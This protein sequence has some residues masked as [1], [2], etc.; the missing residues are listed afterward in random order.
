VWQE[1]ATSAT[2]SPYR[3]TS[4][5]MDRRFGSNWLSAGVSRLEEKQSLLGGRMGSALGGG[6]SASLFLDVEARRRLGGGWS[7]GLSARRGWTDFAAGKFQSGAYAFDLAKS[8]IFSGSDR[9]GLRVAQPLRIERGGFAAW[10]PTSYDYATEAAANSLSRLSLTPS[11]R[12]V[13]GELS[14]GTGLFDGRGWVGG[15]LFYRREP[16]HIAAA[17]DDAGAAIRFTLGF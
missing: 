4:V 5:A 16:G 10:L 8:G 17:D 15:N 11:G 13:D 9:L 1:I 12:E 3:W 7:A 14:Y 6:G 2:G